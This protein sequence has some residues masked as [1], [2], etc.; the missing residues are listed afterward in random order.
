MKLSK[1]V[2]VF[3]DNLENMLEFLFDWVVSRLAEL[4]AGAVVP[5]VK[6]EKVFKVDKLCQILWNN[7]LTFEILRSIGR[8]F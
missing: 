7:W 5:T 2:F 1:I 3:Y 8:I 6:R 4:V